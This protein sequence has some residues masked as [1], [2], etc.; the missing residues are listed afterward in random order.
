MRGKNSTIIAV[1]EGA[2]PIGGE[3][4]VHKVVADSPDPM[5]LGGIAEIVASRIE[6]KTELETRATVLG[7]VQRGGSPCAFD[8]VLATRFGHAAMELLAKREFNRVVVMQKGEIRSVSLEDVA[9]QQRLVPL[10]HPLLNAAQCLN[11]CFGDPNQT[12]PQYFPAQS[13][14]MVP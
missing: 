6:Q 5:R 9:N 4:T 2:Y 3:Q 13:L 14:E 7:H 8:R 11:T 1:S 10:D 12:T